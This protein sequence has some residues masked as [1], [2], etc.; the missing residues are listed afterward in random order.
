MLSTLKGEHLIDQ[1]AVDGRVDAG[2]TKDVLSLHVLR[3]LRSCLA[4]D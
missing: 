1:E 4:P 3:L 2:G